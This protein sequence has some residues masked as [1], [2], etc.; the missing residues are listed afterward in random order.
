MTD[1]YDIAILGGGN[2][3]FGV[4]A[5]AADAGKR[6]AFIEE[7]DFGGTCPNRGCTPKKV[8]VAAAHSLAE[9][10]HAGVHGIS[11]GPVSLDWGALIRREKEMIGHI[12]EAMAGLAA[13]RGAVY[14]GRG[15][16]VGANALAVDGVTIE[17]DNIVVATGSRPRTLPIPGA[18]HMI[19]SDDVLARE[20]L[21]ASVVFV[22]GGVIAMEFAHVYRRA[23]A[24]VTVL[25]AA[26]QLLPAIDAD[27][28]AAVRDEAERI[29]IAVRT[30]VAVKEIRNR[31]DG[32][33]VVY[34]HDGAERTVGADAVVNGTGRVAN[35]DGLDLAAGNVDHD[36]FRI[37]TDEYL[38][39]VSN[40]AVWVAGDALVTSP[41]LSPLAT[42][43]G[44]IVG[45]NIVEGPVAR[46][47]YAAMPS[48]VYT[49][50]ALATV[51]LTE[52]QAVERGLKFRKTEND[53]RG[54][55]SGKSYGETVAWAKVLIDAD[56]DL[57]LGAHMVGHQ[58]ENLIHLFAMAMKHGITAAAM[59]D[60]F[61]AFPTFASDV[62]NLL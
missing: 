15:R 16:F 62:R 33:E 19:T 26:P 45:R 48:C 60:G 11:V 9:I 50:P 44:R 38:R 42:Y 21:P 2:A 56:S 22:G 6:I 49:V 41:Q 43:E 24:A 51:G 1:R 14:R 37:A 53:M 23:G 39:S 47:D 8:L 7:R 40:P 17:A 34:E 61:F 52:R 35:L 58:G 20:Y 28:V 25:E 12:P 29:G 4:S 36:G 46:P 27:A 13:R 55:F 18:E 59:R 31:G 5:V 10:D 32:L 54:W 57:I 30:G 3:G